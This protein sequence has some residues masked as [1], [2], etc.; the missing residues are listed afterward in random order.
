V[1][2]GRPAYCRDFL[3]VSR[4]RFLAIE[5]MVC[6]LRHE[7]GGT[8]HAFVEIDGETWLID[9]KTGA[10]AYPET[11]LQL[12]GLARAEFIGRPGDAMATS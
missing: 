3:D 12:A 8:A 6:S 10:G 2:E 7:Y 9:Y 5:A 4:P 1:T 11:A